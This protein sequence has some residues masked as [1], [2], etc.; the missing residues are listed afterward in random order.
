MQK[1]WA[2]IS[3]DASFQHHVVGAPSCRAGVT[4]ADV[5]RETG[6]WLATWDV[7]RCLFTWLY[8]RQRSIAFFCSSGFVLKVRRLFRGKTVFR[9][10]RE[11]GFWLGTWDVYREV[12]MSLSLIH[13]TVSRASL[14]NSSRSR[15]KNLFR[16]T[17]LARTLRETS[18]S[19][20]ISYYKAGYI[21]W[22]SRTVSKYA[23]MMRKTNA[24]WLPCCEAF[25][26]WSF[27]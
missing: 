18:D 17:A 8:S 5:S 3:I 2:Q 19:S 23:K 22:N 21:V 14:F 13:Q 16:E 4:P 27:R 15:T 12:F 1:L 20:R 9:K 10:R 11:T 24:H 7:R 6:F 26:Q 25:S